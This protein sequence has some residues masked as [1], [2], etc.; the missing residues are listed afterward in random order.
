MQAV[1]LLGQNKY[2]SANQLADSGNKICNYIA[3]IA[4]AV[5]ANNDHATNTQAK[6]TQFDAILAQMK[7]LTKAIAKLTAKKGNKNVNPNTNDG[8]KGNGKRRRPQGR[9]QAQQLTKI[10]NMGGY[11]HSHG[12]HPVG[13]NQDSK[14]CSWKMHKHNDDATWNNYMGSNTYWTAAICVAIEQQDHARWKGK[15][16]PT[17]CQGPGKV[18][19]EETEP[20]DAAFFKITQSLASNYYACLSP[21]P[22]QAKE[23]KPNDSRVVPQPTIP[24]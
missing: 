2:K 9:T 13:A 5:A 18:S 14:N 4:S 7:A 19:D 21:P 11:C 15:S 12:F 6:D 20:N 24:P 16:A 22:C 17:N 1:V 8:K 10:R 3:Q 23:H